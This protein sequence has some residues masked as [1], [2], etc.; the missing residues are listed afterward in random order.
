M[1]ATRLIPLHRNKGKTLLQTLKERTDYAQNPEKTEEGK[2][3]SSYECDPITV[4]EEFLLSKSRYERTFRKEQKNGV[5]AYQIRQSFKPGEIT[6]EEANQIGFE[7]AMRFTKGKYAFIVATH[8]D[9]AHIHNHILFNSTRLDGQGKFQNFFLSSFAIQR[10]SDLLCLEHGLSVIDP[11][12]YSKREKKT[13]WPEKKTIRDQICD[14]IDRILNEKPKDFETFLEMM[15]RAGYEC[16]SGKQI[17]F[18]GNNQKRFVRM[19]SL[20]EGY[21]EEDI[22]AFITENRERNSGKKNRRQ[23]KGA[24][25]TA[26]SLIIDIQNKLQ[27]K[28]PGYKRWATVY[29]LKQMSKTLLFL[30]DHHIDSMEQLNDFVDGKTSRRDELLARTQALDKQLTETAALKK[31]IINYARTRDTYTA[32][33]KAGYSRKFQEEHQ[34]EIIL[35]KAAKKAFDELGIKKIPKVKELNRKYTELLQEKKTV[36]GEYRKI[37]D[38]L[39]EYLIARKN[40]EMMYHAEREQKE[41]K[42]KNKN[43]IRRLQDAMQH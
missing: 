4:D 27:E 23:T 11:K 42:D 30:R 14:D 34:E 40:I 24:E 37:R 18:R 7:L 39:Q 19:R 35:H 25:K 6:P 10:I 26:V 16:K 20:G 31:H 12:P 43:N 28:G 8:T 1:A 22:R 2:L 15:E 36:Y 17:A 33:R 29:N 13:K 41:E 9:K 32:Y 5:I 38:E 21:T 3:I